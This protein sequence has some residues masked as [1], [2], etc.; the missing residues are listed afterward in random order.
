M[1]SLLT[2]LQRHCSLVPGT[3]WQRFCFKTFALAD[4]SM[5]NLFP[6]GICISWFLSFFKS[7][8]PYHP[9]LNCTPSLHFLSIFFSLVFLE[10]TYHHLTYIMFYLFIVYFPVRWYALWGQGFF[11]ILLT[12]ED[13]VPYSSYLIN[14]YWMHKWGRYFLTH[15]D[16]VSDVR[17]HMTGH[18]GG[19]IRV[20][21]FLKIIFIK[22]NTY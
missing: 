14:I 8:L 19:E 3:S 2:S 9:I 11:S 1:Y 4:L 15:W 18:C 21:M 13:P 10:S 17:D 20:H 5:W 6:P 22:F 12:A 7:W 16:L